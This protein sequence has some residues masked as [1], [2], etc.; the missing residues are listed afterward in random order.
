MAATYS[1]P[2]GIPRWADTSGNVVEPSSA[3]KDEGWVYEEI[4]PSSYENWRTREIGRWFKWLDERLFDGTTKDAFVLKEPGGGLEMLRLEDTVTNLP[5]V[6]MPQGY[7][8]LVNTGNGASAGCRVRWLNADRTTQDDAMW[9]LQTAGDPDHVL[10][11]LH[12]DDGGSGV[13]DVMVLAGHFSGIWAT[14]LVAFGADI[15]LLPLGGGTNNIGLDT[16]P[17]SNLHVDNVYQNNV[18]H[19]SSYDD[20]TATP[21]EITAGGVALTPVT[22]DKSQLMSATASPTRR[23]T[24]S[25]NGIYQFIANI[26]WMAD[27]NDSESAF[28]GTFNAGVVPGSYVKAFIKKDNVEAV[29]TVSFMVTVSNPSTDYVEIRG[30]FLGGGGTDEATRMNLQ[31][32]I[33]KE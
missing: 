13:V 3:K 26:T 9:M 6:Y 19:I 16:Y 30:Q 2:T 7:A 14:P 5:T 15:L 23:I 33:I 1:K 20:L 17:W 11:F 25:R 21:I 18:P 29:T 4:P 28:W 10:K 8:E 31:A 32:F 24:F 22:I 12:A 27:G